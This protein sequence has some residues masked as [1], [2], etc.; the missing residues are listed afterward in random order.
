MAQTSPPPEPEKT[1]TPLTNSDSRQ[2]KRLTKLRNDANRLNT[3]SEPTTQPPHKQPPDPDLKRET[4]HTP[5][6]VSTILQLTEP[7]KI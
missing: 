3:K 6:Q 4:T 1:H 5:T 2:L 7:P